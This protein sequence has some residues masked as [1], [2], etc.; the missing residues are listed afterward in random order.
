MS[1]V[2]TF[3]V[4]KT[5]CRACLFSDG[6]R[7]GQ[8][9]RGGPP[10]IA[11]PGGVFAALDNMARASAEVGAT[12]VDAVGAGLAGLAS[13]GDDAERLAAA[14][15]RRYDTRRV[16]LASD[17]TTAH[18]GALAGDDGVVV[19]AGTGSVAL[20]VAADGSWAGVGGWGFLLG[21]E[22]SGYAIGRAGLVSALHH[23][24]GRGGSAG[25]ATRAESHFG[26]L[27]TLPSIVHGSENAAGTVASFATEVCSAASEGDVAAQRVCADAGRELARMVT[28]AARR[29][30]TGDGSYALAVAGGVLDTE[31]PVLV[32]LRAELADRVPAP[33]IRARAG[34]G[35]DGA[36][37]MA[38]RD[39]LPHERL[40]SRPEGTAP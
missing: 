7:V 30:T 11:D 29:T 15:A 26:P 39:D 32:S 16:A 1:T 22:G 6:V 9:S 27:T 37:L 10:G 3:D 8:A 5:S 28:A 14:L 33:H 13:S 2:L 23:H 24:D 31:N 18:V 34:D 17:M 36:H 38:L 19:A 40:I 20:G 12:R 4:G 35:C 25:L 21:D